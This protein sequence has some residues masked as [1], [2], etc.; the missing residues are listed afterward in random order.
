MREA[1]KWRGGPQAR[2]DEENLAS[3]PEMQQ[4]ELQQMTASFPSPRLD[5]DDGNQAT[6]GPH[7]RRICCSKPLQSRAEWAITDSD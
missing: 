3:N 1:T 6:R 5:M 2:R 7:A 4:K